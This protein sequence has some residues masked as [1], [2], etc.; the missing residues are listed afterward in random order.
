MSVGRRRF[1][2]V[3]PSLTGRG[4]HPFHF[5]REVLAAAA[6]RGCDCTLAAWHGFSPA[7]CPATWQVHTPFRHTSYSKY[8][9]FGELDQ[10]D[11]DGLFPRVRRLLPA[12][13]WRERRREQR[14]TAFAEDVR[15][16]I[17]DLSPGD[18]VLLATASELEATGLVRAITALRPPAGIGW[19]VLFHFPIYRGFVDDFPAQ[20][21]R[22][23]PARRRLHAAT[24]LAGPHVIHWHTTTRE[25]AA[26]YARILPGP[27][28]DLPYPIPRIPARE[29]R[30]PGI[31]RVAS[32]G[33]AR[34]EKHAAQLP[35]VVAA[36]SRELPGALEFA[37]QTNLGFAA[38]SRHPDHVAVRTAIDALHRLAAEGVPL[39][40]LDGPLDAPAYVAQLLRADAVLLAYD[41]SRY[42]S[43]CSGVTLE[44]LAAGAAPIMTGGGWM[45]RQIAA[46]LRQHTESLARR[47]RLLHD[48]RI[49]GPRSTPARPFVLSLAGRFAD[50]PA[51][52][53]GVVIV[54]SRWSLTEPARLHLPPLRIAVDGA[55]PRPAT[56][57]TPDAEGGPAVAAF[58]LTPAE[59]AAG[60]LRLECRPGCLAA[61][62]APDELR[63]RCLAADGPLPT[64]AVGIVVD[65]P[66]DVTAA[67][68]EFARHAAH[69][70][71]TAAA[72]APLVREACSGTKVV[73]R[74]LP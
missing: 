47:S 69:Y 46:P 60:D 36:C 40:L 45:A 58:M 18:V 13:W 61:T 51:N 65:S 20:D 63:V 5:A 49:A 23:E 26:H 29:H 73:D 35:D 10:R 39:D 31:L 24:A 71:E 48:E 56:T 27:V 12:R 8:T 19:H 32:L 66:A 54:E 9:A 62:A 50:V 53:H 7:D 55:A 14:I 34:P 1:V 37:I 44:A 74:L 11:D 57:L 59:I 68:G 2:L 70:R 22:L 43:R 28:A 15:P 33:D 38:G 30:P 52:Q 17:T 16:L 25:L 41:Q 42:R 72:H 64:S 67:V 4:A 21:P 6:A 3:D